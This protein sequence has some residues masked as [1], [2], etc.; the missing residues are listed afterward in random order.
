MTTY[1]GLYRGTC[2]DI[3]DPQG[4]GRVRVKV[5]QLFG[6]ATLG[7]AYGC[8]PP[9][10]KNGLVKPHATHTYTDTSDSGT[11]TL[12]TSPH[13]NNV[14]PSGSNPGGHVLHQPTP[15]IGEGVWVMFEGGD[16]DHPV[17][18]GVF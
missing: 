8:K 9:G 2:M 11:A 3:A 17:W 15:A 12:T 14:L 1:A 13:T 4:L 18:M 5:P 16:P 6:E 10:W 7:W